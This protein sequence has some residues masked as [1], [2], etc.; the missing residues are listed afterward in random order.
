MSEYQ[1]IN[2]SKLDAKAKLAMNSLRAKAAQIFKVV[3][4]GRLA[5]GDEKTRTI[6]TMTRVLK[7]NKKIFV[8]SSLLHINLVI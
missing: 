8:K 6:N 2:I 4:L 3:S 1:S 5:S 7:I